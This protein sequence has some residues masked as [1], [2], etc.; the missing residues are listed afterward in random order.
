MISLSDKPLFDKAFGNMQPKISEFT[1]TN[2]FLW[3][4]AKKY[5]ISRFFG[6]ILVREK[7]GIYFSPIG[8]NPAE[9]I[10]RFLE[11][12]DASFVR[13]PQDVAG[14]LA[15]LSVKEDR[16]QF[17]YVYRCRDLAQLKGARYYPKR[18]FADKAME[19][20]VKIV[21]TE[22]LSTEEC[23]RLQKTWYKAR[24]DGDDKSLDQENMAIKLLFDNR[25]K[26][27][28][29]CVGAVIDEKLVA[30]AAGEPLNKNTFVV[31]FEKADIRY[32]GLYQLINR[33]FSRK[34]PDRYKYINREQDLGI[35]GLRKAK[36]SYYPALM[37]KKYT[38]RN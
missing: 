26:L 32:R 4:S 36:K 15:G 17:D 27:C 29:N 3:G 38:V 20:G 13:V 24:Q 37:V 12:N 22:K 8:P 5:E 25:E 2:L 19:Y 31:H 10:K 16:S 7:E 28:I 34:V 9:A 30:F 6:H 21:E 1:F 35:P 18:S 23:E 11:G 14:K 33:E